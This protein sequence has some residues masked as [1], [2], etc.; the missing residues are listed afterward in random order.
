MYPAALGLGAVL[1]DLA[2]NLRKMKTAKP[3]ERVSRT[4]TLMNVL[5]GPPCASNSSIGSNTK[6]T[7]RMH[8]AEKQE[9]VR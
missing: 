8:S 1:S 9:D 6:L 3:V 7:P 2:R 5:V 4:Q